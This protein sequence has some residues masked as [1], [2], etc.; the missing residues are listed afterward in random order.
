[1]T[2]ALA[3]AYRRWPPIQLK[4]KQFPRS[5]LVTSSRGRPQQVVGVGLVEFGEL[6]DTRTNGQ[7]YTPQQTTDKSRKRVAS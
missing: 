5:I 3:A 6:H 4:R 7:R 1:M 2:T